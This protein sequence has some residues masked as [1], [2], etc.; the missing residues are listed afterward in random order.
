MRS[1]TGSPM[2]SNG[3]GWIQ[4]PPWHSIMKSPSEQTGTDKI[5]KIFFIPGPFSGSYRRIWHSKARANKK[6]RQSHKPDDPS[7][8]E[9]KG[10]AGR[11][12]RLT[13][14][15]AVLTSYLAT[16][17]DQVPAARRLRQ[18]SLQVKQKEYLRHVNI[19]VGKLDNLCRVWDRIRKLNK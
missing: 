10:M 7:Q 13:W 16:S 4:T 15:T 9:R 11:W 1:Q 19:F 5:W 6:E 17:L 12:G 14:K 18:R 3:Y 2:L 8:N